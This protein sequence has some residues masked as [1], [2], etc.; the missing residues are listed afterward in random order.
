MKPATGD[1]RLG[2]RHNSILHWC[3]RLCLLVGGA[4]LVWCAYFWADAHL[5]QIVQRRRFDAAAVSRDIAAE[6]VAPREVLKTFKPAIGA[7]LGEIEIP[8]I[9]ISVMVLEGDS[10]PI[11]RR[12]AGHLEG[13]AIPGEPGNVAIAAHRDTFFRAL[14]NIR[15]RDVITLTTLT[16]AYRYQVE[17]VEVVGPND[18]EVLADSPEPILTL[19]TCYPF[20]YVG[21]APKRFIVR[22]RQVLSGSS[23][24]VS[25]GSSEMM[26]KAFPEAAAE[27]QGKLGDSREALNH[28][29][30]RSR[31]ALLEAAEQRI[32][33]QIAKI[34]KVTVEAETKLI[35][36]RNYLVVLEKH[37]QRSETTSQELARRAGGAMA[38]WT[39]RVKRIL[40]ANSQEIERLSSQFKAKLRAGLNTA[41]K[42]LRRAKTAAVAADRCLQ[43]NQG[44]LLRAFE[45]TAE[46]ALGRLQNR[47]VA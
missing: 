16:G 40:D 25:S 20:Y 39:Q 29:G 32:N 42:A 8:S 24:E 33:D 13:T 18:T 9:G 36:S 46:A 45:Q 10:T 22:A 2:R 14:R 19:I 34:S 6:V 31:E 28:Q 17:S 47:S 12:A 43:G 5:Y 7:V 11:L 41:G 23:P 35:A 4:A 21:P 1:G 27:A 37:L 30:S 26:G 38:R 3:S 44:S 15:D